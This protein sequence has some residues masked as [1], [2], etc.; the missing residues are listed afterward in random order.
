M[1]ELRKRRAISPKPP[2]P[3]KAKTAPKAKSKTAPAKS[4]K[5]TKAAKAAKAPPSGDIENGALKV[6]LIPASEVPGTVTVKQDD[7]SAAIPVPNGNQEAPKILLGYTLN[8]DNFGGEVQSHDEKKYT[9]KQ[10]V[11]ES[12]AGVVLFTYPKA[13]TPGCM[14][15][16]L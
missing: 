15:L 16:E 12:K 7:A 3:K 9:L 6:P 13:S 5:A 8:F 10:L 4:G 14:Y 11:E 2:P 1:V